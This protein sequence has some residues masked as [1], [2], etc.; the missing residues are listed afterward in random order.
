MNNVI[1]KVERKKKLLKQKNIINDVSIKHIH[2]E[3][4]IYFEHLQNVILPE[5]ISILNALQSTDKSTNSIKKDIQ[6]LEKEI[7]SIKNRDEEYDYY[8][9]TSKILSD[10][11]DNPSIQQECIIKYF[12]VLNMN[13]P[14]KYFQNLKTNEL[15]NCY[16]CNSSELDTYENTVSCINCGTCV[17]SINYNFA[18]DLSYKES[19]NIDIVQKIDYKRLNYFKEQLSQIQANEHT[20]I[21]DSIIDTLFLE[22]KKERIT[23]LSTLNIKK[24]KELLKKTQNSKYYEHAPFIIQKLNGN[25][26]L[27]IHEHTQQKLIDMFTE[28]EKPWDIIKKKRKIRKNFFSYPYTLYKLCEL[29]GLNEYLPYFK[30]LKDR[31][32]IYDQDIIWK[33]IITYLQNNKTTNVNLKD[34]EWVFIKTV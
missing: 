34:V 11:E 6:E 26:L 32:K 13:L 8:F 28:I 5:K 17:S 15:I 23:N 2:N 12:N 30:L 14:T 9:K 24:I 25:R 31:K 10:Y 19:K 3:K 21:P 33:E 7:E 1:K 20:N 16:N 18:E 22:L 27:S 4:M 29:L